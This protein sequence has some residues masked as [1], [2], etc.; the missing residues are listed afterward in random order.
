M[1]N[2]M[3]T[4][5]QVMVVLKNKHNAKDFTFENQKVLSKETNESF[6]PGELVLE[7]AYRFEGDSSPDDMC[8]LYHLSATTG[9]NGMLIDA[10][11]TYSNPKLADFVKNIPLRV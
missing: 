4:L 3:S 11:G 6:E 9:T 8:V 7:K 1:E 10:F 5:S 2:E